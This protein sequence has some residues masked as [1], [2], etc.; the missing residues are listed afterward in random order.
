MGWSLLGG[1]VQPEEFNYFH[2]ARVSAFVFFLDA[3][4]SDLQLIVNTELAQ[5]GACGSV[6]RLRTKE[7]LVFLRL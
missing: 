1:I 7:S 6:D 5:F 3:D 4:S 2:E